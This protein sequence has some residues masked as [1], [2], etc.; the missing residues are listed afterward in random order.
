[1]SMAPAIERGVNRKLVIALVLLTV[2]LI[3]VVYY[4]THREIT[5]PHVLIAKTVDASKRVDSYRFEFIT[6]LTVPDGEVVMLSGSGCVDYRTQRMRT[7]ITMLDRSVEMILIN[8]TAYVREPLG[9]WQRANV[10]DRAILVSSYDQL[11]HQRSILTN[12][13]NITMRA[14]TDGWLVEIVPNR[15]DVI[16]QLNGAGL[17]LSGNEELQ[18]FAITYR[19]DR[20]TFYI[21]D[22][23]N[24]IELELNIQGLLTPIELTS[25]IR[26]YGYH[27]VPVIEAPVCH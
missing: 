4:S 13:S 17:A 23:E 8:D 15:T 18:D 25:T 21:T 7:A 9:A 12:A 14:D 27:E 26:L 22:I 19:I 6:A 5:D 20:G 16:T 11:A 24:R 2:A 1:M 10:T 3:S